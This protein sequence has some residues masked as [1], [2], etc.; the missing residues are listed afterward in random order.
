[1]PGHREQHFDPVKDAH[2]ASKEFLNSPDG[3]EAGRE[4]L[5]KITQ[6]QGG[7]AVEQ[8]LPGPPR[9]CDAALTLSTARNLLPR[10]EAGDP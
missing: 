3:Y 6:L 4:S 9:K 1:L 7:V 2:K 8:I 5:C 10:P